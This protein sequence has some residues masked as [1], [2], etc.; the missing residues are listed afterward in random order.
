[1]FVRVPEDGGGAIE[2]KEGG[3][4]HRGREKGRA[5]E[6]GEGEW[7]LVV[8]GAAE[9]G[10]YGVGGE[11]GSCGGGS[12]PGAD[13]DLCAAL[14]EGLGELEVLLRGPGCFEL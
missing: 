5:E 8:V 3:V 10:D 14:A 1:M 12:E 7:V 13:V 11:E 4:E 6:G 9:E 2:D